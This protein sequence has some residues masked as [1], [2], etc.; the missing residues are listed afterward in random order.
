MNN[1]NEKTGE[2]KS[3]WIC[4]PGFIF[5]YGGLFLVLWAVTALAGI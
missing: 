1:E 4:I 3:M 2:Y 5:V